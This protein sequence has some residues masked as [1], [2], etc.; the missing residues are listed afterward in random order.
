MLLALIG[1]G[2]L[3]IAGIGIY[4]QLQ[5]RK[6]TAA[7]QRRIEA[8]EVA[9][10]WRTVPKAQIFPLVIGY[11]LAGQRLG[12]TDSLRL[13][14]RRLEI[15][16]QARCAKVAGAQPG[17]RKLLHRDSCQALLRAT[18]TDATN[19]LVLT[20]GVAVLKNDAD[21][22]AAARSLA[23]GAVGGQGS[24]ANQLVLHP[25]QVAGSPAAVFG[26]RQR[27]L[28]WVAAA[29]PYLVLATVGFADGRPHV[30][31]SGDS[32]AYLEMT[33]LARA[34]V[35]DVAGPLGAPPPVPTCPGLPAC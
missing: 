3:A 30:Q 21:A 6:F 34:V 23:K 12:S 31:V 19:S 4:G 24:V 20:A 18:Y 26:T 2:G 17:P 1:M 35:A 8:W 25:F 32:Y 13:H 11:S 14:A 22:T 9:K 16:R 33:S 5:P 10:R 28:S 15:A 29:G 7:Q 27:Q